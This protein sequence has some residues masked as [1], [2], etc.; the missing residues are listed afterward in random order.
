MFETVIADWVFSLGCYLVKDLTTF[1]TAL[2]RVTPMS[3]TDDTDI[4][5]NI[6]RPSLEVLT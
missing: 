2:F 1:F 6:T 3:V 4:A 5:S